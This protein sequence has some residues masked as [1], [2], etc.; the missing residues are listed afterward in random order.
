MKKGA[1]E[2]IPV[3]NPKE[4]VTEYTTIG[5]K[6]INVLH[7]DVTHFI[8]N[9]T[10]ILKDGKIS[11]ISDSPEV[12]PS[13]TYI[14]G[15]G[16]FLIPGLV[17]THVHLRSSK[18]DLYL[19]LANGVTWVWEMFGHDT[20]LKWRTEK[21]N[22]S[23]SPSIFVATRKLGSRSGLYQ[24]G[25]KYFNGG[26]E[27][28]NSE[29]AR[30]GVR[31]L[32]QD[33]YDAIK[34]GSFINKNIY[35]I[36]LDEAKQQNI[37]VLGH[38]PV[39]VGLDHMYNS[40]LSE[41]AHVEELTKNMIHEFGGMT[42]ENIPECLAYIR[43]HAADAAIKLR[44]NNIAV[45][46]TIF[47]ME[48]LPKQ[49]FYIDNYLKSIEIEYVYPPAIE[50]NVMSKGWLPNNNGYENVD[51]KNNPKIRPNSELWWNAYVEAIHIMTKAL[52]DNGVI[53]L[54]GTDA[55]AT[56]MVP[57]FSLHNELES[58][59]QAG[60]SQSGALYAATVAPANW[61]NEKTGVIQVG[62]KAD[63][64]I[65]NDNPLEDI[66]NTREINYVFCDQFY[67]N[68]EDRIR[69]LKAIEETNAAVRKL[70]ISEWQ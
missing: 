56:G 29:S 49:K 13:L 9:Q 59:T 42:Y 70:N 34:L 31:K 24:W 58:L 32:K 1:G 26:I 53:M 52:A 25:K 41:L 66:K 50:G 46:T 5:I 38:L 44:E 11:N 67:L 18:N 19:Y 54:A 40:G 30:T 36:V 48:S 55:N 63:L 51:I 28:T 21:R 68:N 47:L 64:V 23:I 4:Y 37:R 60:L 2:Y 45:S 14:D 57:G 33:G 35:D 6:N 39:E 62:H 20:H 12:D 27:F 61:S 8:P 10:V 17:D 43:K 15:K 16:K 3:V 65:L 7:A 69:L 22:G